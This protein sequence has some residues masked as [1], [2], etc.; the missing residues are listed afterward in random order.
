MENNNSKDSRKNN[1]IPKNVNIRVIKK[2]NR[3]PSILV[4]IITS[5]ILTFLVNFI[6]NIF[7]YSGE[8]VA[9]SQILSKISEGSYDRVVIKDDII[10]LEYKMRMVI[11]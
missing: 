10:N 7:S 9:L 2:K 11:W 6:I 1:N 3:V 4:I 5:I 8:E